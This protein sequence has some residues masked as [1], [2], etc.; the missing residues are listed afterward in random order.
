MYVL[1]DDKYAEISLNFFSY[2]KRRQN[3]RWPPIMVKKLFSVLGERRLT[4]I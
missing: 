3:P 4:Q 2:H 1:V